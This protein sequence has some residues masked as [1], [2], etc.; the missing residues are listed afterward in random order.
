MIKMHRTNW[1]RFA[2]SGM[3]ILFAITSVTS[4]QAQT[5]DQQVLQDRDQLKDNALWNYDDLDA[6]REK[7]QLENKPLMVVLRCI[8]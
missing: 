7:A 6:A 8:P 2:V 5:R 3:A 1:R 4:L